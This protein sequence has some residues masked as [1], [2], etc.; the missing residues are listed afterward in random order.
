MWVIAS[1]PFW[2]MGV[3]LFSLSI[4]GLG[5]MFQEIKDGKT[6]EATKTFWGMCIVLACSGVF[7]AFAAKIAS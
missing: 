5:G 3:L 4:C 2:A 6:S 7:A 1:I